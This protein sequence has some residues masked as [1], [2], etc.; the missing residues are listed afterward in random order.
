[1]PT[2]IIVA[3]KVSR[4]IPKLDSAS[5]FCKVRSVRLWVNWLSQSMAPGVLFIEALARL[6]CGSRAGFQVTAGVRLYLLRLLFQFLAIF[7]VVLADLFF[8]TQFPL[9]CRSAP[10][11]IEIDFESDG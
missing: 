2:R 1:M 9:L 11:E 6:V 3:M 8:P 4:I 10:N 7:L 5:P